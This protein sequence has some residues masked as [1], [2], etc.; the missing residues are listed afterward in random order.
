MIMF[1]YIINAF[2]RKDVAL[3]IILLH[4]FVSISIFDFYKLSMSI[5]PSSHSSHSHDD[6]SWAGQAGGVAQVRVTNA[7]VDVFVPKVT[8][9]AAI[10]YAPFLKQLERARKARTYHR[11]CEKKLMIN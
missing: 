6:G 11:S 4:S 3:K 9:Q 5:K 2:R 8:R 10:R 1:R 7:K